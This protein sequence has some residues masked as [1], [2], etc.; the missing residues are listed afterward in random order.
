MFGGIEKMSKSKNNV[1]EPGDIIERFGA[2]T[3][4]AYVMFA[5]PADRERR[6]VGL[7]RGGRASLPAPA[8]DT[9]RVQECGGRKIAAS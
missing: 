9:S 5:G 4:R 2:D 7:R 3:A 6:V 8:V 1:V